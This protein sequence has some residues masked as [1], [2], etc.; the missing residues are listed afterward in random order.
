M[1]RFYVDITVRFSE[2]DLQ[3][4][5]FFANYL[6]YFDV[7]LVEYQKAVGYPYQ[8]MVADGVDMVYLE[9]TCR[10]YEGARFDDPLRVYCAV[11]H[12]GN[13]SL[14][15]GFEIERRSDGARIVSGGIVAVT[16][17]H[18]TRRPIRVPEVFREAILAYQGEIRPLSAES[19]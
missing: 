14:R 6:D 5:V 7:A 11:E 9:A 15:F 1:R 13:T 19:S 8:Q 3:G 4:H 2:T 16:V 17:D 12:L 10:Y 18:E